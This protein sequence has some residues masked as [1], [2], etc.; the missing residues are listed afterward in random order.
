[1]REAFITPAA[2]ER[3]PDLGIRLR[4][5][6][7]DL[8]LCDDDAIAALAGSSSP[9]GVVAVCGFIDVD[10]DRALTGK[11]RMVALAAQIRDPGN[12]GTL[13]RCADAAGA[14]A[15]ILTAASA[16][17]YNDKAVRASAGSLFHLPLVTGTTLEAAVSALHSRHFAVIGAAGSAELT[18]DASR[19]SGSLGGPVAWVFGNEAWGL[20]DE[21]RA[22]CDRE[23]AVPVYGR[24]ESLNVATAAALCLYTTAWAQRGLPVDGA[25]TAP[26]TLTAP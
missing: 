8:H 13:I 5:G 11:P 12:M 2:L 22:L 18:L 15:V 26:E 7:F 19:A 6:P 10:L 1:V 23:V 20:T 25:E 4:R 16:D 3:H 17:P 24:A 21:T 14:D 9:Q